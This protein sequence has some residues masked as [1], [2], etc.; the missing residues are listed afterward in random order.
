MRV[1]VRMIHLVRNP[2]NV[3]TTI[4]R[5]RTRTSLEHAAEM[6]FHRCQVNAALIQRHP[7]QIRTLR[8]EELIADPVTHLRTFANSWIFPLTKS[9]CSRAVRSSFRNRGRVSDRSPGLRSWSTACVGSWS[10]SRFC[11]ATNHWKQNRSN[12]NAVDVAACG[13]VR[14]PKGRHLATHVFCEFRALISSPY[15]HWK[16]D[17]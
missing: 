1:P 10:L 9:M 15:L 4:H 14:G 16:C 12:E 3:I 2:F 8:L 6:Y 13:S 7:G 11:G 5:K 17:G